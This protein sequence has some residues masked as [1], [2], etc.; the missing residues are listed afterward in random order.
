MKKLF[1]LSALTL[2]LN[3]IAQIPT[4]GL[5]GY[6]PFTGNANDASGNNNNGTVNG[7]ILTTDRF[8]SINNAYDFSSNTTNNITISGINETS[9]LQYSVTGWFEKN[10]GSAGTEGNIFGQSNPCSGPGGLRFLIGSTNEAQWGAEF[11]SCSSMW[12]LT[13]GQNY[14]DN[15][16]HFFTVTFNATAGL[17]TF[18]E[19]K[20]YIDNVLISQSQ[21]SQGTLSNVV[22]PITNTLGTILGNS[23]SNNDNFQGKLDDIRIYNRVLDSAEMNAIYNESLCY[24]T[25][26]VTDTLIINANLTGFNPVTYNNTIKI[27]PNP[28]NTSI[29]INAGTNGN[30][31]GYTVKILNTLSQV[32]YQQTISTQIYTVN[33]STFGGTGVY[34][35]QLYNTSGNL[36]DIRKIMLE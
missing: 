12:S 10:S 35:V 22:A 27:Y 19:F 16:W 2:S 32:V 28:T 15:T 17:I 20:I 29:T 36:I 31:I 23:T 3:V 5:I 4:N 9:I 26:T 33:L 24:Q 8:G 11:Q 21:Y 18:N 6:Y 30:N 13:N 34:F 14:A 1:L 25:I 7:S